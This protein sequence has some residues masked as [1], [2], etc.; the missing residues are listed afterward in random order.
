MDIKPLIEKVSEYLSED[1]LGLV[2]DAYRYALEAHKGQRRKS[3]HP[4]ITHPLETAMI[5]ADLQL[6]ETSIAAALLHDVPENCG[7]PLDEIEGR[8]GA[9]VKKIVDGTTRL[10]KISSQIQD[11]ELE[12]IVES[13][14]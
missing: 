8:F 2:E 7:I 11:G 4:Y 1:K 13:E 10:D 12:S 14:S 5:V 6:D 3:G 9:E